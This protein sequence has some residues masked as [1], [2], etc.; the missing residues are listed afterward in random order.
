MNTK[1]KL[2]LGA[3][4]AAATMAGCESMSPQEKG[5]AVGAVAGGVVGS[6]V[7][8]GSTAGTVGGAVIGGAAGYEYKRRNP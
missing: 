6:A 1:A 2:I 7:S 4:V 8:G 3:V 5:A